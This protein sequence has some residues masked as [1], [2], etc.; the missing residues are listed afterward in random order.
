MLS[1]NSEFLI[2]KRYFKITI[3]KG[4]LVIYIWENI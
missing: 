1:F 3:K 4:D 2:E